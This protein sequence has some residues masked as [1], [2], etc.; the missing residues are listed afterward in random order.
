[1]KLSRIRGLAPRSLKAQLILLLFGMTAAL[2]TVLSFLGV[3]ELVVLGDRAEKITSSSMQQRVQQLLVQT[4]DA[5]AD[6]NSVIFRGLQDAVTNTASYVQGIF[7]RPSDF[8]RS[9]WAFEKHIFRMAEGQY[10]N[11]DTEPGSVYI[12]AGVP[13]TPTLKSRLELSGYLD[14]V[15]PQL[16]ASQSNAVAV[17]YMGAASGESRY[18]P[19]IGLATISSP[20]LNIPAQEF[21]SVVTPA[22][23]PSKATKWTSVYDD[24]AGHGLTITASSPMYNGGAFSGVMGIDVTLNNIAKNIENYSP[25]ESS[26]AFLVDNNGR[27]VALPKQGYLDLLGREPKDKEFGSDLSK[28]NGDFGRILKNMRAGE[29]GFAPVKSQGTG[30]YVAYAPVK[31]TPFSLGIV[32]RQAAMLKVVSDLRGQ[33]NASTRQALYWQFIPVGVAVLLAVWWFGFV[34]IKRITGPIKELTLKTAEVAHGNLNVE[35][36]ATTASNELGQLAN[37]FNRMVIE[38]RGS[39]LKI[40]E[41]NQKLLQNEQTRLGASINSLHVGFIMTD[42]HK[43]VILLNGAARKILA[44][45]PEDQPATE[46]IDAR[47]GEEVAFLGGLERVLRTHKSLEKKAVVYNNAILRVFMSPILGEVGE[48]DQNLGV[49]V[50][51]EDITEAKELERSK[52]EFFSIASHELRTPLTAVRGNSAMLQQMYAPKLND[53]DF[54]EMVSDI[55][56]A[57][58]RLI[59]IVNDFLDA[60]RLE[61]GKIRFETVDFKLN[62]VVQAV[63]YEMATVAKDKGVKLVVGRS[64]AK[65]P[66]VHADKNRVKQIVYNLVGN[67]LKFTEKGSISIDAHAEGGKLKVFVHDN[68]PGISEENQHMLFRKFQQASNSFMTRE[69][70][71]TGMGLYISKLLCEQMGGRI[72]LEKSE[73]GKGTTFS[74]TIPLTKK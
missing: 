65:L 59:E 38:L 46:D 61:Q 36:A 63:G 7:E 55:H 34:Y 42:Q 32:A 54:D 58:V 8:S 57:S 67:A 14:Y 11:A 47:M 73:L 23:D 28:I 29:R 41:Q 16:L 27:A 48:P 15:A 71:G 2:V 43:R 64:L 72:A 10:G 5:T 9:S 35:P 74:F 50:L 51:L 30:L 31:D 52:D 56:G 1:M 21:F 60:T 4:T 25:I 62:E 37:S 68:G 45:K 17:Y 33:V 40:K 66:L 13:L 44:L 69:S 20:D 53:R 39:Q 19:N 24:P 18:Y 49:V 26:Y 6:K 70:R 3:R 22:A 12:S